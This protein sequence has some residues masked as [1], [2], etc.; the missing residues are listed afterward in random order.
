[1]ARKDVPN[2]A[3]PWLHQRMIR[4]F[5][6]NFTYVVNVHKFEALPYAR[7]DDA[8][9]LCETADIV[10]VDV[11]RE[12]ARMYLE[13]MTRRE[14]AEY[15]KKARA[16]FDDY[17]FLEEAFFVDYETEQWWRLT[18]ADFRD[19]PEDVDLELGDFSRELEDL[20]PENLDA[21]LEE[22]QPEEGLPSYSSV[23]RVNMEDFVVLD[24]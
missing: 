19:V 12:L 4:D 2:A 11:E 9:L 17:S 15:T 5:L 7:F 6:Y 21:F 3:P 23:L 18:P 14:L 10:I 13:I 16:R 20:D 1:M 22:D 8:D 24:V